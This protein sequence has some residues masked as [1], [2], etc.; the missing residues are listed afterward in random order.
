[1]FLSETEFAVLDFWI[2]AGMAISFFGVEDLEM[3]S[4][5]WVLLSAGLCCTISVCIVTFVDGNHKS[6]DAFSI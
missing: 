2:G 6:S 5:L 3:Y 1:M 4:K